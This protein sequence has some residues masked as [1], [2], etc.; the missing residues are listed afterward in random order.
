[1]VGV[2]ALVK[3]A[4]S[5]WTSQKLPVPELNAF[6]IVAALPGECASGGRRG[7]ASDTM[8]QEGTD[9]LH[10][11]EDVGEIQPEAVACHE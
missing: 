3:T 5:G 7:V 6:M 4:V 11:K 1:V 9:I 2:F 10:L 8:D